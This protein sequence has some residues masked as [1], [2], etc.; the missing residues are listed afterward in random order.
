M[1][2]VITYGTF[3]LFHLGHLRL[4][5][6][7]AAYGDRLVVGVSS[8]AFNQMKNKECVHSYHERARIVEAL[9]VVDTVF[10]EENWEQKVDDIQR[11]AADVF[12][13][14]SDWEGRFDELRAYCRV[15]Y[16]PRTEGV[17]TTDRKGLIEDGVVT[18]TDWTG[19]RSGEEH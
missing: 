2:T 19:T 8:D 11:F 17:S 15:V 5:E 3:D 14:G 7:A 4:L 9:Q 12:V 1:T 6:R 18:A 16:L 10:P 13:M